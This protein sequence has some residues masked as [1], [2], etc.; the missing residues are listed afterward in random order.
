MSWINYHEREIIFGYSHWLGHRAIGNP[1]DAWTYPKVVF[2]VKPDV[3]VKLGSKKE[4]P[5]SS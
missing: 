5:P 2:E 3:I 1:L 4:E